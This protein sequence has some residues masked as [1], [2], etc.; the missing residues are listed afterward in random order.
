MAY[1]SPIGRNQSIY[2]WT[3]TTH[4]ACLATRLQSKRMTPSSTLF[5]LT[6]LKHLTV[7]RKHA[8]Y[9]MAP[10]VQ[11]QS[12]S[13][14]KRMQTVSIRRAH[15]YFMLSLPPRTCSSSGPTSRMHSRKLLPQNK[16]STYD[17]IAPSTSGGST[18]K[19]AP[20]FLPATSSQSYRQCRVTQNH[21]ASGKNMLTQSYKSSASH[22]PP[23]NPA[24]TP[25]QLRAGRRLHHRRP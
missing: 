20:L 14:T 24:S 15:A 3:S 22:P 23:T 25:G 7:G 21:L 6:R 1:D 10:H 2:S 12:R 19:S 8:A 4:K 5:G 18:I 13:W 17:P 11:A 16:A 9:A